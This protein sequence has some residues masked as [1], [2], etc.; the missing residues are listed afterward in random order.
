MT[1]YESILSI[2]VYKLCEK[3]YLNIVEYLRKVKLLSKLL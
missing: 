3:S 2:L 1:V